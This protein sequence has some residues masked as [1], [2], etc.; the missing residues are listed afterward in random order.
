MSSNPSPVKLRP[1]SLAQ[2]A[3]AEIERLIV[4]G[5]LVPGERINEARLA[6][7]L[8]ISRGPLRE[9]LREMAADGWLVMRP[10]K[11]AYV[12]AISPD[13]ALEAFGE[14]AALCSFAAR[15]LAESHRP[16]I[17]ADLCRQVEDMQRAVEAN[18]HD[19]FYELNDAFHAAIVD[20]VGNRRLSLAHERSLRDLRL[21]R[22]RTI[23]HG[24]GLARANEEHRLIVAAIAAGDGRHAANLM[25][26]HVLKGRRSYIEPPADGINNR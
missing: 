11:G 9:A 5:G 17:I 8:G 18:D 15:R 13:E 22:M 6:E 16:E 20:A 12:Q 23:V 3:R 26:E 2:S 14:R 24:R 7:S 21:Y 25:D 10:N 19:R 4:A 1:R